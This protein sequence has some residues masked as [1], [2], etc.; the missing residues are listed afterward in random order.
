MKSPLAES[1]P[2]KRTSPSVE[3][4][5]MWIALPLKLILRRTTGAVLAGA[6]DPP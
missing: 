3:A 1:L 6:S 4:T 5:T 2:S